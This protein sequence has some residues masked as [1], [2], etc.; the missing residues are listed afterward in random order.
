MRETLLSPF[1]FGGNELYLTASSGLALSPVDG[2]TPQTL[3]RNASASLHSAALRGNDQHKQYTPELNV[4]ALKRLSVENG[5]RRALE[6]D[7]FLVYYQPQVD[8]AT[9]QIVGAEALVRWQHPKSGLLPP[10]EFI[11]VAE[12]SGLIGAI[13]EWVMGAAC[14]Q[15]RHWQMSGLPPLSVSVNLSPRQFQR[16]NLVKHIEKL[17]N[18]SGLDPSYLELELTESSLMENTEVGI[19]ALHQLK[20]MGVK[21][22]IDDFG[23]GYSSLCYLRQLPIDYLKIDRSFVRDMTTNQKDAATV[24]SIIAL[25]RNFDLK[26]KAE[27]VETQDQ[28]DALR[29]LNCDVIQGYWYGRPLPATN[30]R[31]LLCK[32]LACVG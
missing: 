20:E 32:D 26:V 19:A 5:L 3:L 1:R 22:S 24:G 21:L 15:N 31:E 23:S 7:E 16:P 25:A 2:E 30:F 4:K 6:R 9:E 28:L 11:H 18:L 13:G 17:L 29:R 8:T 12:E 10:S 27:G 14:V